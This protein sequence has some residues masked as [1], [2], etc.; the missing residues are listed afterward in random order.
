M[1]LIK[2][3]LHKEATVSKFSLLTW[4]IKCEKTKESLI[5]WFKKCNYIK[6]LRLLES[7]K[8]LC[9]KNWCLVQCRVC[10]LVVA[11]VHHVV[12]LSDGFPKSASARA[13][14]R[15]ADT[16]M[17]YVSLWQLKWCSRVHMYHPFVLAFTIHLCNTLWQIAFLM[18][19]LYSSQ[20]RFELLAC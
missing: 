17:C 1:Q 13:D 5:S 11:R 16:A 3:K 20:G 6:N 14:S 8:N 10:E 4:K 19:T 2:V 9:D 7:S 18:T 12:E 15:Q